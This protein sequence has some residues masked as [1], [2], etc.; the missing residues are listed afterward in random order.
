MMGGWEDGSSEFG[1]VS[2]SSTS[3]MHDI[4]SLESAGC[5]EFALKNRSSYSMSHVLL[6]EVVNEHKHATLSCPAKDILC[7]A[8]TRCETFPF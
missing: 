5:K 7:L 3:V 1:G 4:L 6:S 2:A 8:T